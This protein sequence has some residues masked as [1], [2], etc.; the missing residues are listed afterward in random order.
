MKKKIIKILLLLIPITVLI[1]VLVNK[2]SDYKISYTIKG[3]EITEKYYDNL[4]MYYLAAE[5]DKQYYEIAV[6]NKYI[7]DHVVK[8]IIVVTDNELTCIHFKSTILDTYPV[9][10]DGNTQFSYSILDKEINDFFELNMLSKDNRKYNKIKLNAQIDENIL[11]WNHYGFDIITK[12]NIKNIKIFDKEHYTDLNS[13]QIDKYV[14]VPDYDQKYEFDKFYVIDITSG[15]INIIDLENKLSF[16]YYYLGEKDNIGY[17]FDKK[18]SIEYSINPQK[19][20]LEIVSDANHGKIWTGKWEEVSLV[21]LKNI[22]YKFEIDSAFNYKIDNNQLYCNYYKGRNS[23]LIS[24]TIND[25]IRMDNE[26]VY[27]TYG[28]NLYIK[29]PFIKNTL[30]LEYDEIVFNKGLSIYIY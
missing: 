13:F 3:I 29:S 1:I 28:E 27:Y 4:N 12:N 9:C 25:I 15:K 19:R 5:Y 2:K 11:I 30:I 10:S 8:D 18:N 26:K 6:Y 14:I 21:K 22:E 24:R 23:T 17:I 7:I 20:K 16:N